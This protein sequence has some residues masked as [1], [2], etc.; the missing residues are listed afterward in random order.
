[1][2]TI[3]VKLRMQSHALLVEGLLKRETPF[4]CA[5][6]SIYKSYA[7]HT[8]TWWMRICSISV[9]PFARRVAR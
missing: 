7:T 2:F 5:S 1:M 6:L 4:G 3:K 9:D 8:R